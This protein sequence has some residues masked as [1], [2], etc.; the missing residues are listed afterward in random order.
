MTNLSKLRYVFDVD[1]D[2][3]KMTPDDWC[4]EIALALDNPRLYKSKLN[5]E[6]ATLIELNS[7]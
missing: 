7:Q 4:L 6:Y 3:N 5:K 1:V 2:N